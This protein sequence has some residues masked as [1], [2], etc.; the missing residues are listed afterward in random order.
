MGCGTLLLCSAAAATIAQ[1]SPSMPLFFDAFQRPCSRQGWLGACICC[2]V[3]VDSLM[4]LH[5]LPRRL[6]LHVCP[7]S[8]SGFPAC[9]HA[10]NCRVD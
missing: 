1:S 2:C 9:S 7:L 10:I 8:L 5:C 3:S 4:W 6:R